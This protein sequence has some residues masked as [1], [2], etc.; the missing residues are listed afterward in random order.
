MNEHCQYG[1]G[2]VRNLNQKTLGHFGGQVR[3]ERGKSAAA[4]RFDDRNEASFS[5]NLKPSLRVLRLTGTFITSTS[6]I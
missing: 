2:E 1:L 4:E 3:V 5:Q 6:F